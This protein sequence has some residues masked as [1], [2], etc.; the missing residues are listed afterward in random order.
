MILVSLIFDCF[1]GF[2]L[3][4][5][6]VLLLLLG[7]RSA[8][9]PGVLPAP[10]EENPVAHVGETG[11]PDLS[12]RHAMATQ[13]Y[14]LEGAICWVAS[15]VRRDYSSSSPLHCTVV[16]TVVYCIL[17]ATVVYCVDCSGYGS[18]LRCGYGSLHVC[19]GQ[20]SVCSG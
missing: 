7:S 3:R 11:C 15:V 4:L 20:P 14:S 16:A 13:S 19:G 18:L 6:H 10:E 9:Q 1:L 17:V 2:L 5:V 12:S 8:A